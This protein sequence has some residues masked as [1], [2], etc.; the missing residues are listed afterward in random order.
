MG[1]GRRPLLST[2]ALCAFTLVA[3]LCWLYTHNNEGY[4]IGR[5]QPLVPAGEQDDL[6]VDGVN[7]NPIADKDAIMTA[8][9]STTASPTI[10]LRQGRYTGVLEPA[11]EHL[12][13]AIEAWRGIP[14][15]QSTAAQNR[16][17]PPAPLPA[18]TRSFAAVAFGQVCPGT[19]EVKYPEGEDCLNLNVFRQAG[20]NGGKGVKLPVVVYVHGGAFNMGRAAER[21]MVSFVAWAEAPIIGVSFNYRV[22]ALGFL[23]SALTAKEGLLN[24]GLRDQQF[25][26]QWVK[27]NIG[28]FGGDVDNITLMGLSAGAHSV[29]HH[30]MSYS[31]SSAPF[32]KVILESGGPTAR[33]TFAPTHPRHL[34]QFR[35]F[36]IEAGVESV[37]ERS[38]FEKLRSLPLATLV[39]ASRK[40]WSRYQDPV[41]W[42]FQ[43]VIDGAYHA[44]SANTTTAETNSSSLIHDL[45]ILNFRRGAFLNIPILTGFNTNEGTV[46][47]PPRAQTN[48]QF[49]SFFTGM[50]PSLTAS[51]LQALQSLYPD[52]VASSSRSPYRDVPKGFGAQWA[53][54]DAAYAHYAY[55]CPVL[56]SAHFASQRGQPVYV[57]RFAA[58]AGQWATANHADET[59]LVTHDMDELKGRPGLTAVA[60]AMHAAWVRFAV[61]GDPNPAKKK[62]LAKGM[63]QWPRFESPFRGDVSGEPTLREKE[64]SGSA[65]G[66]VLV[67]GDGNDERATGRDGKRSRGKVAKVQ[68]LSEEEL[69][70][71]RFWWERVEL[72]EGFGKRLSAEEEKRVKRDSRL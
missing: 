52:P 19:K 27:D 3:L 44:D 56:Q 39:A 11:G 20:S 2:A 24:L 41:C 7:T 38:I 61:T 63:V 58:R 54:L 25:L 50:I 46:F 37:T 1:L 17:R 57:Y 35:E 48:D 31:S 21:D 36:L 60:D 12:P 10:T 13:K 53:R 9:A 59:P 68:S 32:H 45:P 55:S 5:L 4:I 6:A 70:Q 18:S 65:L 14:Y 64:G 71:C 51:D 23:P 72:S 30:L 22:G 47:V 49:L 15:A 66:S 42:P 28:A 16:F 34:V 26:F 62:G 69:R 33:A 40:V 29:G 43:P 67:F 8:T